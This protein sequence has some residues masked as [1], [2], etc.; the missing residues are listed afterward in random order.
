MF[1]QHIVFVIGVGTS[2]QSYRSFLAYANLG[3]ISQ[4]KD[5]GCILSSVN[6]LTME[7]LLRQEK[8]WEEL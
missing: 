4:T 2:A 7:L 1:G 5:I 3:L 6:A 8:T